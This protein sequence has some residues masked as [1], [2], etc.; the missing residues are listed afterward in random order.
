MGVE[1]H[2]PT[3]LLASTAYR[4]DLLGL[5]LRGQCRLRVG[6]ALP[7]M[8]RTYPCGSR[9]SPAIDSAPQ[10]TTGGCGSESGRGGWSSGQHPYPG[11]SA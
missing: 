9:T 6:P 11:N 3:A 1:R 2:S 10:G 7:W 8:M 5:L 4:I